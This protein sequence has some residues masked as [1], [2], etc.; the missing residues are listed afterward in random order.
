MHLQDFLA[1][2]RVRKVDGDLAVETAR[3]R[4]GCI[5]NVRTVG[6]SDDD[7]AAQ[8]IEAVHFDEQLVER[9]VLIGGGGIVAAPALATQGVNLVY[10]DDAGRKLACFCEETP[11]RSR[12]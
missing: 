7:D 8:L 6:R 2:A 5:E 12:A 10:E 11:H 3:A 1:P 9:L 4:Q